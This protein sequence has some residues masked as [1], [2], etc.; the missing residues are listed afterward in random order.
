MEVAKITIYEKPKW[1]TN[2]KPKA[3]NRK[4]EDRRD[5]G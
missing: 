5:F 2:R 4:H 3:Q 1:M